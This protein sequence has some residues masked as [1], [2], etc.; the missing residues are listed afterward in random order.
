MQDGK[1]AAD[2]VSRYFYQT[3]SGSGEPLEEGR[4]MN[5]REVRIAVAVAC[6]NYALSTLNHMRDLLHAAPANPVD[7]VKWDSKGNSILW[8]ARLS[9]RDVSN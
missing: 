4:V 7:L 5:W 3:L 1:L 2:F 9:L 6:P 8:S